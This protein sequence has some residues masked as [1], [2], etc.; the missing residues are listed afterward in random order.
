M[1]LSQRARSAL[2]R[3]GA[4]VLAVAAFGLAPVSANAG[5]LPAQFE[6]SYETG[7]EGWTAKTDQNTGVPECE[8]H[9]S[10]V[11]RST[12]KAKDGVHSVDF[13]T[14]GTHDCGLL[15]LEREFAVG[16]TAPV[17]LDLSMWLWTADLP[18]GGAGGLNKVAAYSGP[19][20]VDD[21][22][23]ENGWVGFTELG[24]TGH[25]EAAGWY[26]YRY[27]AT[28]TPNADGNICVGQAFKIASTY[29]FIKHY[30]LD[31]TTVTL[32]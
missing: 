15:W 29:P 9:V 1:K 26:E 4:L 20:C 22:V 21:P 32:S 11:G 23:Q 5:T 14:D 16:T 2:N 25:D 28:V 17:R 19:T 13:V 24:D 8:P 30:Y 31:Q 6:Y 3:V 12:A 10:S 27:Q 7:F 18:G